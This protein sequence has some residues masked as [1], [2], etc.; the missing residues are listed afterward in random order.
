MTFEKIKESKWFIRLEIFLA[1]WGFCSIFYLILNAFGLAPAEITFVKKSEIRPRVYLYPGSN[2]QFK[3][4]YKKVVDPDEITDFFWT[5][6]GNGSEN[7]IKGDHPTVT[8]PPKGGIYDLTARAVTRDKKD[9]TGFGSI[10]IIQVEAQKMTLNEDLKVKIS[11][12][13]L[14]S[15]EIEIYEAEGVARTAKVENSESGSFLAVSKGEAL[16][17]IEGKVFFK[18]YTRM[19]P[20]SSEAKASSEYKAFSIPSS[21]TTEMKK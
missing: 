6:K 13:P 12:V 4:D 11:D 17:A 9:L 5:L 21:I 20:A 3:P 2:V 16:P 8:L 15:S 7:E 10:Y 18:E 14:E 1:I 19:K